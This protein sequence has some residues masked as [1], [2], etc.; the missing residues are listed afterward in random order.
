MEAANIPNMSST[1]GPVGTANDPVKILPSVSPSDIAY[2][3]LIH[4][5]EKRLSQVIGMC[6]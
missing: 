3:H 2:S 4:N 1:S 5:P 6:R